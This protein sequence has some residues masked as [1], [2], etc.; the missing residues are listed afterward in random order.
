MQVEDL[1]PHA[2][3]EHRDGLVGDQQVGPDDDR[4]RDRGALLLAARQ[5]AREARGEPLDGREADELERLADLRLGLGVALGELVDLQR[6]RERGLQRH[7]GIQRRVRVLEDH[8]QV[9]AL[10]PQ[11]PLLQPGQLLAAQLHAARRS[12]AR[13][14]AARG[15]ASSCPSPTR[16]PARAP[17]PHGGRTTR[18]RR[19]SPSRRRGRS[20]AS[21]TCRA[22]RSRPRGRGPRSGS[23]V[24]TARH[25]SSATASASRS[26]GASIPARDVL[27]LVQPALRAA[28]RAGGDR[29]RPRVS[30]RPSSRP[31]SAGGSG[32]PAAGRRGPAAR[33]GSSAARWSRARSSSAAARASTGATAWS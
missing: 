6:V 32:R 12:A 26:I 25:A 11:L 21:G 20:A 29:R 24:A 1:R 10:R 9:P 22:A 33:P 18:R 2:H 31:G 4:A 19:P 23:A 5:V 28:R 14:R 16:R 30:R 13:A 3:V 7:P 15:R 27:A 8:L 17:R